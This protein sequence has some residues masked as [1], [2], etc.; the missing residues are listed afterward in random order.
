MNKWTDIDELVQ[1]IIAVAVVGVALALEAAS[2]FSAD[3]HVPPLLEGAAGAVLLSYGYNAYKNARAR[4][5]TDI[6]AKTATDSKS[7]EIAS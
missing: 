2:A 7:K 6:M 4:P 3:V 1:N 5:G